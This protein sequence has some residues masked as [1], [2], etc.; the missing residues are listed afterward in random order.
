MTPSVTTPVA[1][2]TPDDN[3]YLIL[4]ASNQEPG[5]YTLIVEVKDLQSGDT[6]K[7]SKD[8]FLE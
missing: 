5:L 4:D 3:Q 2:T 6:V 1:G 8:L 7:R